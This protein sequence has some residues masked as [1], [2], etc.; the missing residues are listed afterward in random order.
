[1]GIT[2]KEL[3]ELSGYSPA[4]ISRVIT[5]KGNVKEET[6]IEI[7]KLLAK[8][9]Y[10][11]N[12]SDGR[13]S[14]YRE[15]TVLLLIG[16]MS[17]QFY[18]EQV[19]YLAKS[20][21]NDNYVPMIAYTGG[22]ISEEE[23]Y[24]EMAI[25]EGYAGIVYLNVRGGEHLAQI[26]NVSKIPAVFL[27]RS[28]NYASFD[29]V[30]SDNYRGGYMAAKYLIERGHRKIG[31]LAGNRYSNT[32]RER[33]RGYGDAMKESGLPVS[34]YSIYYGN[35]DRESGYKFGET[36]IKED[37]G[38]T[39][40]FCGNDLMADGLYRALQDYGVRIP[41]DI[42]IVCYDN[43][44]ISRNL[45]VTRVSSNPRKMGDRA[46]ELLLKRISDRETDTQ[47]VL[48]SPVILAGES[49]MRRNK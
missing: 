6:R 8:Y 32:T 27:N 30:C 15:R 44:I 14:A 23:E 42:S 2:I 17:N 9:N 5:N 35:L 36:I 7:Q 47:S 31:H 3:S 40:I 41:E 16:D 24:T 48:F 4:T 37:R 33:V 21:R 10:K 22:E 49:V 38:Y 25:S 39:A 26:L 11:L 28:I 43:T 19:T 45:N 18:I 12:L 13:K 34:D 20:I 46:I 1:M 29:S